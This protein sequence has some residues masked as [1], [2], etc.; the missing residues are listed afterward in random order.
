MRSRKLRKDGSTRTAACV[1]RNSY[2]KE[3]SLEVPSGEV[4]YAPSPAVL[5]PGG[6][7][8][9]VKVVS[10]LKD[11]EVA[12]KAKLNDS[13]LTVNATRPGAQRVAEEP[14]TGKV[15]PTT[16]TPAALQDTRVEKVNMLS[17]AVLGL[18]VLLAKSV[19]FNTL[20]SIKLLL[21]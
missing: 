10:V 5:A 16:D 20:M 2:T 15:C 14:A 17:M 13:S 8:S 11:T 4:V 12:C 21:F 9:T 19:A 6:M 3:I 18:R 1:A 7:Y